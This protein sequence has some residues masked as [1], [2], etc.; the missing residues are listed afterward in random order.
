MRTGGKMYGGGPKGIQTR[1]QREQLEEE[2]RN[3]LNQLNL[4]QINNIKRTFGIKTEWEIKREF[5]I[6]RL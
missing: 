6:E 5:L 4:E 3:R 2:V 1:S